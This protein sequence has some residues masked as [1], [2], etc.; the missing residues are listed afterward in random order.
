MAKL[1]SLDLNVHLL[2][3]SYTDQSEFIFA[4][5]YPNS[6][7]PMREKRFA[8]F[9]LI[10]LTLLIFAP[11]ALAMTEERAIERVKEVDPTAIRAVKFWVHPDKDAPS[12]SYPKEG[13]DGA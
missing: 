6:E 1:I 9:L 10:L 4:M 2:Y 11:T 5:S 3:N 7:A 8:A 13:L 12:W